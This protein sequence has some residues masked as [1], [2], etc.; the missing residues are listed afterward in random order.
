MN[1]DNTSAEDFAGSGR[2]PTTIQ[3]C[4]LIPT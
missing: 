2:L 3:N 4:K 1:T